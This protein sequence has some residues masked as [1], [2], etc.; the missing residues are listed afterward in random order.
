VSGNTI[1]VVIGAK[2]APFTSTLQF[3]ARIR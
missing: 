3:K 1:T 2:S